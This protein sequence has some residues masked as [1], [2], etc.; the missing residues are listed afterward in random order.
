[1]EPDTIDNLAHPTTCIIVVMVEGNYRM[2]VKK[3]LV[4]PHQALLDDF[5]INTST[6]VVV[7]LDMVHENTEN[8]MMEVP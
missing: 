5:E 8:M 3:G 7:K 6:Y 2:E 4:Y 1:L